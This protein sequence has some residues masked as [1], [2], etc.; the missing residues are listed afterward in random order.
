[1]VS[2][3]IT[4][5]LMKATVLNS[6]MALSSIFHKIL[7]GNFFFYYFF[8]YLKRI[9]SPVS[10][11]PLFCILY[12]S[13]ALFARIIFFPPIISL[14]SLFPPSLLLPFHILLLQL[15][16]KQQKDRG[17]ELYAYSKC[18][19]NRIFSIYIKSKP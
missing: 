2:M 1:M 19:N 18:W 10:I 13:T 14:P 6:W 5:R 4:H 17:S 8:S 11:F 16:Y 12:L 7:R 15:S 3:S 9:P